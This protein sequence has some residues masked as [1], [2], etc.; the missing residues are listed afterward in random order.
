M[1]FHDPRC[2]AI[3]T[4]HGIPPIPFERLPYA[5]LL[6]FVDSLQDDR[7]DIS[8]SRFRERGVLGQVRIA[9]DGSAVEAVVR[10][11]EVSIKGWAP[12]MAE[13]ETVMSWIN[14]E[15][16]IKFR[17]NYMTEAGLF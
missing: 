6:M 16:E 15:S 17:I 3:L 2:R 4:S 10:L 9:P 5:S 1:M 11:Q 8:L 13:Y 12:R 7:R 14:S